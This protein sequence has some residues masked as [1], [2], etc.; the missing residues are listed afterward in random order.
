MW[1]S[2]YTRLAIVFA[3]ILAVIGVVYTTL[4]F[5][6][7]ERDLQEISQSLNRELAKNIVAERNLVRENRLDQKALQDTFKMYM[8][9][10]PAIEIYLLDPEGRILSYSADPQRVKRQ[11]VSLTPIRQFLEGGMFPLLGDDPRAGDRQKVFSVTPV[12]SP[13]TPEGY[14]YV[15]LRGEQFDMAEQMIREQQA[16]RANVWV[17]GA[18]LA[19]GLIIGL[20]VFHVLT[21]RLRILSREM[22]DFRDSDF[23][24]SVRVMGGSAARDEIDQLGSTFEQMAGR[25][26]AQLQK[27]RSQDSRRRELIANISH[28]LRTPL[29]TLHGYLETLQLKADELDPQTRTQY[30]G[31]ALAHSNRLQALID[32]LF[33]LAKLEAAE[34]EPQREPFSLAEL[35]QDVLQQFE[36]AAQ[37]KGLSLNLAGDRAAPFVFADIAMIQR[38]LENLVSNAMR[39]TDKGGIRI[40]LKQANDALHVSVSDNG[41][42]IPEQEIARIFERFYQVDNPHRGGGYAGLGLAIVRRILDLH[43]CEISVRSKPDKGATFQFALPLAKGYHV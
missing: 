8:D 4:T 34:S 9:I 15:I 36:P 21:R 28:D 1:H 13:A 40:A 3:A 38:V 18:S 42:G 35:A 19:V 25:I 39:H 26:Q 23:Q 11:R 5:T 24:T 20:F 41:C 6:M 32:E 37:E 27:L 33:E 12:P 30:L 7:A 10:N 29:S 2:L 17:V 16:M 14:L 31:Q 22:V 43:G